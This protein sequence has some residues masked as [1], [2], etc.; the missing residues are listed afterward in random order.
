MQQNQQHCLIL[1]L[2]IFSSY[3]LLIS[4]LCSVINKLLNANNRK[5]HKNWKQ[6]QLY[7]SHLLHL[8]KQRFLVCIC[9]LEDD[10]LLYIMMQ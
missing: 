10:W 5:R 6:L 1:N 7:N 3:C 8:E 4:F 9:I 2:C